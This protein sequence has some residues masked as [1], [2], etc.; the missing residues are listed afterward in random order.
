MVKLPCSAAG[1]ICQA[2]KDLSDLRELSVICI[3]PHCAMKT[4]QLVKRCHRTAL[5]QISKQVCETLL[6]GMSTDLFGKS[7]PKLLKSA[8]SHVLSIT[9]DLI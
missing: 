8:L 3:E 2:L 6:P 1:L 5:G 4:H 7:A 9:T